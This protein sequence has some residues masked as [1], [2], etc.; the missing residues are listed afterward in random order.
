M[1]YVHDLIS[2]RESVEERRGAS[3]DGCLEHLLGYRPWMPRKCI[4]WDC[5][6]VT[7]TWQNKKKSDKLPLSIDPVYL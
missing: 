2:C 5:N 4:V 7:T 1:R 6:Y 3:G